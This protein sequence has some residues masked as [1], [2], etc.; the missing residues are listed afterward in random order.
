MQ[1]NYLTGNDSDSYEATKY[2]DDCG[3]RFKTKQAF[4]EIRQDFIAGHR[5]YLIRRI[6]GA[7]ILLLA[8]LLMVLNTA[9]VHTLFLDALCSLIKGLFGYGYWVLF[10]TLFYIAWALV[11]LRWERIQAKV[12]SALVLVPIISALIHAAF[13][14]MTFGPDVSFFKALWISGM[15]YASGGAISGMVAYVLV[16]LI[17]RVATI[18]ILI[19]VVLSLVFLELRLYPANVIH[20]LSD[21]RSFIISVFC[22]IGKKKHKSRV[23]KYCSDVPIVSESTTQVPQRILHDTREEDVPI[24]TD[25]EHQIHQEDESP[26]D[27][28]DQ[29]DNYT[30]RILEL[31]REE[32]E[33]QDK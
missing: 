32:L 30:A 33:A 25:I 2:T 14:R 24:Q 15:K 19:L 23:S 18:P 22:S 27:D 8:A 28:N 21:F 31:V 29:Q 1:H 7:V 10:V 13:C 16:S 17:S 26:L 5:S 3:F 9:G 6:A 4:E 20:S 12:I 11:F